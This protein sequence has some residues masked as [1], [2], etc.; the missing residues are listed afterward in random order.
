MLRGGG[1]Q[2][3][4]MG[5]TVTNDKSINNSTEE[6]AR[7]WKRRLIL[8]RVQSK[9]DPQLLLAGTQQGAAPLEQGSAVSQKTEQSYQA[10]RNL[11]LR[12]LPN[13]YENMPTQNLPVRIYSSFIYNSQNTANNPN[14]HQ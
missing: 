4:K 10:L 11:A 12:Y 6:W 2:P 9:R 5:T 7:E 1:E 8:E 3:G 13:W 14:I